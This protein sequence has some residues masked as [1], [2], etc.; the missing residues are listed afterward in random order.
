MKAKHFVAQ[1]IK[2][3]GPQPSTELQGILNQAEQHESREAWWASRKNGTGWRLA[4]NGGSYCIV[5]AHLGGYVEAVFAEVVGKGT[6]APKNN[7]TVQAH[8][9]L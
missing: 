5:F 3:E 8:S 6:E 4:S 1:L 9:D 2:G 7:V